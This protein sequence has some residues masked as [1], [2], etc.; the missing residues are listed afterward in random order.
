MGTIVTDTSKIFG[1]KLNNKI[2][3]SEAIDMIMKQKDKS[4]SKS[5]SNILSNDIRD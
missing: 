4:K 1:S 5:K 3:D 2:S